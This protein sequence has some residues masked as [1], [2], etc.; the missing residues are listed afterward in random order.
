MRYL[1]GMR[2]SG[3]ALSQCYTDPSPLPVV[4]EIMRRLTCFAFLKDVVCP[5]TEEAREAN[6]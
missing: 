5:Y 2:R 4:R 1:C 3:R 6:G